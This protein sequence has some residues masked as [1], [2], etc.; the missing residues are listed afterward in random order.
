MKLTPDE[1]ASL[2]KLYHEQP[3]A[4]DRLPYTDNFNQ[5]VVDFQA[6]FKTKQYDNLPFL[7]YSSLVHLRKSGKLVRKTTRLVRSSS[8]QSGVENTCG[9]KQ[10]R[11]QS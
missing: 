5:I 10:P 3:L 6:T 7:L 1:T 11:K 2:V 8:K 4:V 9:L